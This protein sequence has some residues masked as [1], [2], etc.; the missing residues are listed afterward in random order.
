MEA[1]TRWWIQRAGHLARQ[2][3]ALGTRRGVDCRNRGEQRARV[4]MAWIGIDFVTVRNF[5]DLAEIHNRNTLADVFDHAQVV[6]DEEIGQVQLL[7]QILE[8]V[9]YLRLDR[10]VERRDRLVQPPQ[11]RA[12]PQPPPPPQ[13]PSPP[14][15]K[16]QRASGRRGRPLPNRSTRADCPLLPL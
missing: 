15:P 2:L 6:R 10:N 16:T 11:T 8:Q 3:D 7:L 4:R 14:P 12:H 9:D 5:D 1:A 13:S